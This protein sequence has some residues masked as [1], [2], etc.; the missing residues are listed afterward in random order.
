MVYIV[1]LFQSMT[2]QVRIPYL[3]FTYLILY[4]LRSYFLIYPTSKTPVNNN[5][6][7]YTLKLTIKLYN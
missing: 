1:F 6:V 2:N 7:Q 3:F 4:H 5:E